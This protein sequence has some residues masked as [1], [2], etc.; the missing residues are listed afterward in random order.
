MFSRIGRSKRGMKNLTDFG[1][2]RM[3]PSKLWR[4]SKPMAATAWILDSPDTCGAAVSN[5]AQ[6]DLSRTYHVYDAGCQPLGFETP[7]SVEQQ[8]LQ[9]QDD[10]AADGGDDRGQKP[11]SSVIRIL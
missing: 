7:D 4:T 8:P 5:M 10:F 6:F 11:S 3:P 1:Q 9:Y 2:S